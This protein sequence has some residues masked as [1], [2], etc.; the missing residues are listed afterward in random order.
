MEVDDDLHTQAALCL[1]DPLDR[2]LGGHR[3]GLD[4]VAK[5]KLFA[6]TENPP[7]IPRASSPQP[8]Q[9]H[10]LQPLC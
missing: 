9:I 7:E 2:R 8:G 3:G 5:R 4:A 10:N 6:S 1:S